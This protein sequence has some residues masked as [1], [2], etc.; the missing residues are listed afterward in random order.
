MKNVFT[1]KRILGFLV[2]WTVLFAA[3]PARAESGSFI[4]EQVKAINA[5]IA[6]QSKGPNDPNAAFKADEVH[7][8]L[9]LTFERNEILGDMDR[10]SFKM[11]AAMLPSALIQTAYVSEKGMLN[12]MTGG[13][14]FIDMLQ[15]QG[16]T[17]H[18]VIKG[19]DTQFEFDY[20]AST[21][22]LN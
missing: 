11:V 12:G 5:V 16:Y 2:L 10:E 4:S 7:K 6:E 20:P 18:V 9:T 8:I 17:V 1:R 21:L 22:T 13:A 15:K 19:S 14:K 3:L